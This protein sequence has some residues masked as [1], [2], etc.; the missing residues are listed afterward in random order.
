VTVKLHA[1]NHATGDCGEYQDPCP[2]WQIVVT[3]VVVV[4]VV[5]VV[6]ILFIYMLTD[7]AAW[8]P[9]T[10]NSQV[11]RY[12]INNK[13]NKSKQGQRQDKTK[14]KGNK[15]NNNSGHFSK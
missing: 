11:Q 10:K 12:N 2:C 1:F 3:V 5:V 4:V 15:I 6:L 8:W 9:V 7:S 14:R 13:D